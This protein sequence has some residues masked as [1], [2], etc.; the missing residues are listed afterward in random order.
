MDSQ[1]VGVD[2]SSGAWVAIVYSEGETTPTVD[3]FEEIGEVWDV[4]GESAQRIVVDVPIGLCESVESESCPCIEADGEISRRCDDLARTVI[5]SR[6]SSVFTAPAREAARL[7]SEGAEYADVSAKNN[8]L[9]GKGLTQQAASISNGI[10]E[11]EDL[12]LSDGDAEILVEGHP[13]VCFRAF[14]GAPLEHSKHTAAGVEERLSTLKSVPEYEAGDWRTI[15]RELQGLEYKIG[16][17]DVL[18]AFAL[19]LTACAPHDEFQRLP[20]DPAEDTRGLP[21]QMAYRSETQLR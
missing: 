14:N 13:E 16:I 21:M 9:T 3:V 19:S 10:V 17:D 11:V 4:Y 5:G 20:S 12:L 1:Y 2:W 7:A 18:D 6:S 8:S 15:A